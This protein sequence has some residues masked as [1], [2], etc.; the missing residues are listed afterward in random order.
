MKIILPSML[1]I[2]IATVL[3]AAGSA[4]SNPLPKFS[5]MHGHPPLCDGSAQPDCRVP[6]D[7]SIPGKDE[8]EIGL[9]P[10][11]KYTACGVGDD[12]APAKS[13]HHSI[14]VDETL[15]GEELEALLEE[16]CG[17]VS[18]NVIGVPRPDKSLWQT[19][20]DWASDGQREGEFTKWSEFG[21]RRMACGPGCDKSSNRSRGDGP[22][23]DT[24]PSEPP[25]PAERDDASGEDYNDC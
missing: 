18:S 2:S 20:T 5:S 11:F 15:S 10:D 1:A 6:G 19:I 22:S 9:D 14:Y 23:T 8:I 3:M 25:E 24:Q 13:R 7:G 21:G 17:I 12:Q 4:Q 16:K